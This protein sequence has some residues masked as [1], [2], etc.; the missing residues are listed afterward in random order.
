MEGGM[1][2]IG[3]GDFVECVDNSPRR[4]FNQEKINRLSQLR[5]GDIYRVS[6]I[7]QF[8][9]LFICGIRAAYE[10]EGWGWMEDRFR[11]IRSDITEIERILTEPI[12][13]NL[14]DA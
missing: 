12:P 7:G 14:V 1:D 11:P 5:V 3:P 4:G 8:G 10:H 13:A 2:A 6:G 9:S